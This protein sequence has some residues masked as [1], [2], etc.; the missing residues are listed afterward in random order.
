MTHSFSTIIV[1]GGTGTRMNSE[2]PKQFLPLAG[3]PML[4]W[5]VECFCR[6]PGCS[7]IVVVLPEEHLP[8]GTR[9]LEDLRTTVRVKLVSGGA[10]RQDSVMKGLRALDP[11]ASLVAVHDAARPGITTDIVEKALETARREG[12]AVVALVSVD[13]LVAA[14]S[15]VILETLDRSRVFRVQTPQIFPVSVLVTALEN[16]ERDGVSGTDDAGLVR[17]SGHKVH[18]VSGS[19]RNAKVTTPEDLQMLEAFLHDRAPRKTSAHPGET[20]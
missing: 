17:R 15:G 2:V 8:E 13:T 12:N 10:R 7:E 4:V 20:R 5:S 6:V 14:D 11:G 9:H 18:L 19:I 16:A 1:A 3:K